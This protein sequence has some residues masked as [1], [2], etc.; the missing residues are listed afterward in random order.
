MA[1]SS[2]GRMAQHSRLFGQIQILVHR[3]YN[4]K[5]HGSESRKE[6]VVTGCNEDKRHT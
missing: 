2:G 3:K 6:K 5:E 1:D 4:D